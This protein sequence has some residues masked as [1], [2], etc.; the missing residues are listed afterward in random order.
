MTF[1]IKCVVSSKDYNTFLNYLF[2]LW[3]F[4]LLWNLLMNQMCEYTWVL[5]NL[6]QQTRSALGLGLD[7][8][9]IFCTPFLFYLFFE[10]FSFSI[11]LEFL[12]SFSSFTTTIRAGNLSHYLRVPPCL[13]CCGC[14]WLDRFK[15]SIYGCLNRFQAERIC[16]DQIWVVGINPQKN[17]N[18]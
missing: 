11:L 18:L 8:I 9:F 6:K 16:V 14:V 2:C 1:L 5:I 7:L 4:F 10:K 3:I 15:I 12:E 17:N 13:I